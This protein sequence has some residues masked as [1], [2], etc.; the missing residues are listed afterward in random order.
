[1]WFWT[2]P[3]ALRNSILNLIAE[4]DT[5]LRGIVWQMRG[6]WI[7]MRKVEVL[8]ANQPPLAVDGEVI[9]HRS[10]VSFVQVP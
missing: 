10:N 3:F 1:M 8:K 2:P 4:P 7:V 5:A 9:V 6:D